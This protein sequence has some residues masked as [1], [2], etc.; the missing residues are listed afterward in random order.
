MHVNNGRHIVYRFLIPLIKVYEDL[1]GLHRE[2]CPNRSRP[3]L[4]RY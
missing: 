2:F 3:L 1:P 4:P